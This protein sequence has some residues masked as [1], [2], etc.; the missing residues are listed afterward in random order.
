MIG[1]R[2]GRGHGGSGGRVLGGI[3]GRSGSLR[4]GAFQPRVCVKCVRVMA[5]GVWQSVAKRRLRLESRVRAG[6]EESLR[7]D[8][9]CHGLD[10]IIERLGGMALVQDWRRRLM[11][12]SACCVEGLAAS[13]APE[14]LEYVIG[15][16]D[17]RLTGRDGK[18]TVRSLAALPRMNTAATTVLL[19]TME[20]AYQR[21]SPGKQSH[22]AA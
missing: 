10:I 1:A 13:A 9:G 11:W 17:L 16:V 5:A 19:I 4:H 3:E 18:R 21:H 20:R 6:G 15:G 14:M 7:R 8:V 12:E 22:T 2:R